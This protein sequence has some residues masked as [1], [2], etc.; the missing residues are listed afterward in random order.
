MCERRGTGRNAASQQVD[1]G[2]AEG[3]VG[4]HRGRSVV[5]A[6]VRRCEPEG[7]DAAVPGRQR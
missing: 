2:N 5:H 3:G 7:E 1:E 6:G 4:K